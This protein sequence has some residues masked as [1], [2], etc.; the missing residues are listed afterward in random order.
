M[1]LLGRFHLTSAC[2]L[3]NTACTS[4]IRKFLCCHCP[5]WR[6]LEC[7]I[8]SRDT[9]LLSLCRNE[10]PLTCIECYA[11]SRMDSINNFELTTHFRI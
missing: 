2:A 8:Y 6:L 3:V 10:L 9:N 1:L 7:S 4:L 11:M 5:S